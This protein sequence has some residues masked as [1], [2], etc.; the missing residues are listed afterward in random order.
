MKKSI[1]IAGTLSMMALAGIQNAEAAELKATVQSKR[2]ELKAQIEEKKQEMKTRRAST[3]EEIKVFKLNE[4]VKLSQAHLN[5]EIAKL[6]DIRSR[7]ETRLAKFEQ[8]GG[9]T[10]IARADLALGVTAI[11]AAQ[12]KI[13]AVGAIQAS[14]DT[15]AFTDVLRAAVKAAQASI[16]DA[17]KALTK[18]TS[19][20]KGIEASIKRNATASSTKR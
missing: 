15:K 14:T 3:T 9:N 18:V 11:G 17:Q 7:I 12:T 19:D 13:D 1:I 5:A 20:M 4:T 16:N 6:S 8:Y 2:I 10:T